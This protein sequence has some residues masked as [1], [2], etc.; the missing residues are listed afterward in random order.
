[1]IEVKELTK[2][3]GETVAV[4]GASGSGKTTLLRYL[5]L[6][7]AGRDPLLAEFA[8]ARIPRRGAER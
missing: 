2:R 4:V 5:A 1:M 3:Y 6:K 7:L 8:R